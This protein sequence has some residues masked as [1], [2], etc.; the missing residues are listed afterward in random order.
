M[1]GGCN[2]KVETDLIIHQVG[3]LD[4]DVELQEVRV[5]LTSSESDHL[6]LIQIKHVLL[7]Y[8]D[9]LYPSRIKAVCHYIVTFLSDDQR[10]FFK[11]M[12]HSMYC[13]E[14][15]IVEGSIYTVI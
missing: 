11:V 2:G 13:S 4:E 5:I 15:V 14:L 12:L 9:S 3:Q 7:Y 6:A 1:F 8:T 10:F